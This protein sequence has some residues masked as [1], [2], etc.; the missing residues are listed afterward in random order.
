MRWQLL[1]RLGLIVNAGLA[2]ALLFLWIG[3]AQR[4]EFWRSDFSM[5]YTAWTMVLDGQGGRLYDL[6]LQLDYQHDVVP[7]GGPERGLLPFN[8]PPPTAVPACL[9][10]LLPR[11]AAFYTWAAAQLGL[12]LLVVRQFLSLMKE[13]PAEQRALMVA[14]LLAFPAVLVSFQLGQL[15]LLVLACL[16]GMAIALERD[17]PLV[18]AACFVLA[19]I[20]PQL[21]VPAA[22]VLAAGG[23]RRKIIYSLLLWLL[24]A[25]VAT[26]VVGPHAWL[27]WLKVVG[28]SAG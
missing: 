6:D 16:T 1:V 2:F 22:V 15:S 7:E 26:A 25:G 3:M 12:L 27:D 28:R 9:L 20:K 5:F 18:A 24:W 21:A 14:T 10:A 8:Y 19:T 13:Y 23:F 11:S 4:G 17:R